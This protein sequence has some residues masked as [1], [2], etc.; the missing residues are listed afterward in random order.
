MYR[1]CLGQMI[2]R[3]ITPGITKQESNPACSAH[4]EEGQICK[5]DSQK[6]LTWVRR[7]EDSQVPA[8]RRTN[9]EASL[10]SSLN[11]LYLLAPVLRHLDSL[12]WLRFTCLVHERRESVGRWIGRSG[13]CLRALSSAVTIPSALELDI[14]RRRLRPPDLFLM[15]SAPRLYENSCWSMLNS[16]G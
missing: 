9:R 4:S 8:W 11:P 7:W 13:C 14:V 2:L 16:L 10:P 12:P 6:L 5:K 1:Y 15:W 3:K